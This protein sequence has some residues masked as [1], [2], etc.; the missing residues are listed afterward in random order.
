MI[1]WKKIHL[2]QR[3]FCLKNIRFSQCLMTISL[4][5]IHQ[6]NLY[7]YL[8]IADI[9]IP[10]WSLSRPST[11]CYCIFT[12]D[13]QKLKLRYNVLYYDYRNLEIIH[14]YCVL[15]QSLLGIKWLTIARPKLSENNFWPIYPTKSAPFLLTG[16]IT[17]KL[18]IN[19][20]LV[21]FLIHFL[22]H[23]IIY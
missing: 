9:N 10:A 4:F 14:W 2:I 23:S 3:N 5:Q 20:A 12:I 6:S 13:S 16:M 17:F 19:T 8:F 15:V 21:S 22:S 1:N 7:L 11:A 18:R